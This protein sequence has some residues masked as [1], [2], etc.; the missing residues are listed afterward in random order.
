MGHFNLN[1]Q[2]GR[3]DLPPAELRTHCV[4]ARLNDN[5]L[6]LLDEVR[7]RFQRGEALRMLSLTSMPRPIPAQN[8]KTVFELSRSLGNLATVSRFLR[9]DDPDQSTIKDAVCQVREL[10]KVLTKGE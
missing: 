10:M 5:E 1:K 6:K 4:S 9:D 2:S 8:A 7:G 3:K